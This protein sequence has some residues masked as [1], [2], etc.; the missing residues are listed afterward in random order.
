MVQI[1]GYR[2]WLIDLLLHTQGPVH[3][4]NIK[5]CQKEPNTDCISWGSWLIIMPVAG[6]SVVPLL[7]L[8]IF[9]SFH[10]FSIC[11]L[12]GLF[13]KDKNCRIMWWF[14]PKA[15]IRGLCSLWYIQVVEKEMNFNQPTSQSSLS[16]FIVAFWPSSS[17]SSQKNQLVL[18]IYHLF[19]CKVLELRF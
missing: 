15:L 10:F 12:S 5:S 19:H 18:Q 9:M 2:Y 1:S 3:T 8:N 6:C 13:I 14:A 11:W 4:A 16:L 17:C 7:S